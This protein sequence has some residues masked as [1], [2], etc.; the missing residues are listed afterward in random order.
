M[1]FTKD[2]LEQ[3]YKS[4]PADLRAALD[5]T[6]IYQKLQVISKKHNLLIDKAGILEEQITLVLLGLVPASKFVGQL[7]EMLDITLQE[8]QNIAN[9][10]NETIFKDFRESLM[11]IHSENTDPA[12]VRP[13]RADEQDEKIDREELLR[14]IEKMDD[15]SS[16]ITPVSNEAEHK[17]SV[18]SQSAVPPEQPK[19]I[20]EEKLSGPVRTSSEEIHLTPRD[21]KQR[22]DPGRRIDPYREPLE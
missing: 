18:A 2:E 5:S 14:E 11:R 17:F 20:I 13:P 10:V 4:L 7:R 16:R 19:S 22:P 21:E 8:A 15:D 6:E 12:E 9:D 3:K 1:D